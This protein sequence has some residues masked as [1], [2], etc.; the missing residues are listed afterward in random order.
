MN[1]T[2][3]AQKLFTGVV[4]DKETRFAIAF[5][6]VGLI[7]ENIGTNSDE[8]GQFK[9]VSRLY[10]KDSIR[11]SCVGYQTASFPLAAVADSLM[12][13]LEP[14]RTV[15]RE[16]LIKGSTAPV[17]LNE[18]NNCSLNYYHVSLGAINQVAVCFEAPR[19]NMQLT[20]ISLCKESADALF[21]LRIYGLDSITGSPSGDLT[22]TVIE[23]RSSK[24]K[25]SINLAKY[26]IVLPGRYFFIAVEWLFIPTNSFTMK[27]KLNGARYRYT[28]YHPGIGYKNNNNGEP[29]GRVNK[30][31][32]QN[33]NGQWKPVNAVH[34]RMHFLIAAT[35]Q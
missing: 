28:S 22:D 8:K 18:F 29:T 2:V 10:L 33:Y 13:A 31:W 9:L 21:R 15:L 30:V 34:S 27:T 16:V 19:P 7:H 14:K 1:D 23:V 4:L 26:Y 35:V 25:L 32:V 3:S 12:V 20:E 11:I 6:T 24:R 5:A 17:V